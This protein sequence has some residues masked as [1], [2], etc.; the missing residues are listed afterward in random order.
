MNHNT[1]KALHVLILIYII[2]LV[3]TN[4]QIKT[5]SAHAQTGVVKLKY[6]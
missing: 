4:I 6:F 1:S 5:A 2:N 3:Q